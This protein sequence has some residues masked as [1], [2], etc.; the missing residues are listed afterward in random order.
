MKKILPLFLFLTSI[1]SAQ[2]SNFGRDPF[3]DS[4]WYKYIEVSPVTNGD[5][6]FKY[7]DPILPGESQSTAGRILT[8]DLYKR[9]ASTSATPIDIVTYTPHIERIVKVVASVFSG[10]VTSLT[11][12]CASYDLVA[13][14][15]V[16]IDGV[17]TQIGTT[18]KT[19][20]IESVSTLD[21]DISTDG[22]D[23]FVKGTAL[24]GMTMHWLAFCRISTID[25]TALN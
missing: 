5:I 23:I 8:F 22:S 24:N 10:D 11:G 18:K 3:V 2:L 20:A 17:V 6:I 9:A 12:T 7:F 4:T 13:V 1:G 16:T 21:A 15:N 19:N 25:I 14:F